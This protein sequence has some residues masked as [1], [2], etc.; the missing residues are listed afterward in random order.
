MRTQPRGKP[1]G[2]AV[3][4]ADDANGPQRTCDEV[5]NRKGKD[6]AGNGKDLKRNLNETR[7]ETRMQH[8]ENRAGRKRDPERN[9]AE[10]MR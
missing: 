3:Q 4:D 1:V 10:C 5:Q 7:Q 2:D 8:G 6:D 9:C